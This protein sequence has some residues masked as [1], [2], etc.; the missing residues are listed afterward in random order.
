MDSE[1]VEATLFNTTI[2][3]ILGVVYCYLTTFFYINFIY[4]KKLNWLKDN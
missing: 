4:N 1:P 3:D 2:F